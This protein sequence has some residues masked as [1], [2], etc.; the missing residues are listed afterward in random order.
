MSRNISKCA[1]SLEQG[2]LL[3]QFA[4]KNESNRCLNFPRRDGRLLVVCSKLGGFSGYT[5]EDIVDERVQNRHGLSRNTSVGM[6]LLEDFVDVRRVCLLSDALPLL[7]VASSRL[8]CD[9]LL[10]WCLG[11][12]CLGGGRLLLC[13]LLGRHI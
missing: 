8:G 6:N 13:D 11:C 12:W 10:S 7:L 4:G 9:L 3:G 2:V 5:L 1:S